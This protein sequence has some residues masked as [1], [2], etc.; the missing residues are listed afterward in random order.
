MDKGNFLFEA[1]TS[2]ERTGYSIYQITHIRNQSLRAKLQPC[3]KL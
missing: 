1:L 3:R 2:I